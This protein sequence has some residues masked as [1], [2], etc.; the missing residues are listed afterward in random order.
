[1]STDRDETS[2]TW[3]SALLDLDKPGLPFGVWEFFRSTR[4][5][6]W[7]RKTKE[8]FGL[9]DDGP[10]PSF[11][12]F[13]GFIHPDDRPQVLSAAER[14]I[15]EQV[16]RITDAQG[17]QRV[18]HTTRFDVAVDGL[19]D[20]IVGIVHDITGERRSLDLLR[21]G[22]EY[23]RAVVEDM[24]AMVCR[25][26]PDG[27]LTY[28]NSAYARAFEKHPNQLIGVNWLA[29]L[30]EADRR[31]AEGKIA[32]LT[33]DS[34]ARTYEHWVDSPKGRRWQSWTDRGFF[35]ADGRLTRVQ[36]VGLDLTEQRNTER[37]IHHLAKLRALGD[38]AAS[39][40]HEVYQPLGAILLAAENALADLNQGVVDKDAC[41]RRLRVIFD[42]VGRLTT[43]V[44]RM[45]MLGRPID[46][47]VRTFRLKSV[48]DGA[49]DLVQAQ[50]RREGISIARQ[51]P[52]DTIEVS[53]K[54]DLLTNVLLNLLTNSREAIVERRRREAM[55]SPPVIWIETARERGDAMA[56]LTVRDCGGGV[57]EAVIPR[58]F[59]P[60]FTT[61][62]SQG[63]SGLG[64]PVCLSAVTAMGGTIAACNEADGL[65]VEIRLPLAQSSSAVV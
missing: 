43:L 65:A 25:F 19:P 64:L 30:P 46:E 49:V 44:S 9:P 58:L 21:E 11:E 18:L 14:E 40:A 56:I 63:G 2:D 27:T 32:S 29:F 41:Q 6:R 20:H 17:N 57:D 7:N 12:E 59:E 60:F 52:D 13:V 4:V 54:A 23:F 8:F 42:Q 5:I 16:F 15:W 34:P 33:P 51:C 39:T 10:T 28:V 55:A 24:P 53:G 31:M 61:K 48:I 37:Q 3:T 35:D 62:I 45:K 22:R 36:S 50:A 47:T 38:L 26:L 1:M